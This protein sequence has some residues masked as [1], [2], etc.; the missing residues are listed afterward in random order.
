MLLY[1]QLFL[2][3]KITYSNS[4]VASVQHSGHVRGETKLS[5]SILKNICEK[6]TAL[7]GACAWQEMN[8]VKEDCRY[9][10]HQSLPDLKGSKNYF[11]T[12]QLS[13]YTKPLLQNFY[14]VPAEAANQQKQEKPKGSKSSAIVLPAIVQRQSPLQE[15]AKA[16]GG[17]LTIHMAHCA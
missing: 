9:Q 16:P 10:A 1:T 3:I 11:F 14:Q 4:S 15:R 7:P 13:S 6:A 8:L 17:L 5:I 12:P 2:H